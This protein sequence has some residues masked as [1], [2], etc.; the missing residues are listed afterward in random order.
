MRAPARA[1]HASQPR[2]AAGTERYSSLLHHALVLGGERSPGRVQAGRPCRPR[3]P[4]NSATREHAH[5]ARRAWWPP[6]K[7]S[8]SAL[9]ARILWQ[10]RNMVGCMRNTGRRPAAAGSFPAQQ[11]FG[12][13]RCMW[14][15]HARA[16]TA[17]TGDHERSCKPGAPAR[18]QRVRIVTVALQTAAQT[19]FA[20]AAA[21]LARPMCQTHTTLADAQ[22]PAHVRPHHTP[23]SQSAA[24]LVAWYAY[25]RRK[26][27]AARRGRRVRERPVHTSALIQRPTNPLG[28]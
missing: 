15:A 12:P 10:N 27:R 14:P 22:P 11:G 28:A 3:N 6:G 19:H 20:S 8:V 25:R 17:Q 26:S 4:R 21:R 9:G 7:S 18:V 5:A 16:R 23:S 2:A 13:L 24:T 1:C